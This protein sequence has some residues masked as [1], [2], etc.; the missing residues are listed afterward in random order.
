MSLPGFRSYRITNVHKQIIVFN[1][2]LLRI[3]ILIMV[4]LQK[5]ISQIQSTLGISNTY[6]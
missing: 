1:L 3:V 5:C 6:S 2:S 4:N